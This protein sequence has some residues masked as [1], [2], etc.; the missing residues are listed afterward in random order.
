MI[1]KILLFFVVL[2]T[3]I[4]CIA[5]KN[6]LQKSS[7]DIDPIQIAISDFSK[8][9]RLFNKDTVFFVEMLGL[10]NEKNVIVVRIGSNASKLLLT[11]DALIGSI[12]KLPSRYVE[13]DSRLFFWWDN[14]C[15]LTENT[16]AILNKYSLLQD[17]ENGA[18]KSPDRIINEAR[19][20]AHY[21]F[22]KDD[23][24]IYKKVITNIGVGYYDIPKLDCIK[25]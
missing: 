21:Y 16:L 2:S 14:E 18:I 1:K 13:K 25:N 7:I 10:T 19:K 23:F 11:K 24:S 4:S 20:A 3:L 15:P 9:S 5:Y 8:T 17:D 22:C 6:T 12:G